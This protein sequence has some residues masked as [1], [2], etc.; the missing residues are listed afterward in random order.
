MQLREFELADLLPYPTRLNQS[1][2]L[3]PPVLD[4][5]TDAALI[6]ASGWFL[7]IALSASYLSAVADR[8][9]AW[10]GP[11]SPGVA[12]ERGMRSWHTQ[13]T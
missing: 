1:E 10:G 13:P 3:L 12:G 4:P 6:N 2:K 11:G 7:R 9:G 5:M 8:F